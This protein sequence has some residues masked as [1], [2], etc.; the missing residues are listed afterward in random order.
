MHDPNL[1]DIK[2]LV[3]YITHDMVSDTAWQID[4][5]IHRFE[6]GKGSHGIAGSSPYCQPE[7]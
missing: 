7:D 5:E 1:P 2:V 3:S 6:Q 4:L